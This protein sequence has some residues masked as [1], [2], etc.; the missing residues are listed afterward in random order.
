MPVAAA[1]D[2]APPIPYH[3]VIDGGT[4]PHPFRFGASFAPFA[5][6]TWVEEA[7]RIERLGYSTLFFPDHFGPQWDPTATLAAVGAVTET[8]NVGSLVYDVDYR[9]PVVF[10]KQAAT[11]QLLT[12]GRHEFGFGAG[13][14]ETDYF[15]AGMP[16]DRPGLRVGRM[17]EA[18]EIIRSMWRQE[19]TSFGGEHYTIRE[20][21]CAAE[22]ILESAPPK[23]L[24]G[25]GG[26]RVLGIAGRHADI[27]GIN[28][29]MVEG[30]IVADTPADLAPARVLEKVGWVRAAAEAAGRDPDAIEFSSLAWVMAVNDD[31][32]GLREALSKKTG[33]TVA[34][35]AD[36]PIF[37][38]GSANEI[39][40][41]LEKRR[42][43]TGISYVTISAPASEAL[44]SFAELMEP[45]V[46]R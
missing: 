26:R 1:S 42:E 43:E 7:R 12:G 15:E 4:M 17:D 24:I 8:L 13:W 11:I 23:I 28:P 2:E 16:Y 41:R 10:A 29:R 40:E 46:G 34:E 9:H 14:M 44:E 25:G 39:R 21:A 36:C 45:L 6:D 30:K 27:V 22:G 37:L 5:P 31:P 18:L 3:E 32:K 35:V 33:M 38:T 20:I 19:K